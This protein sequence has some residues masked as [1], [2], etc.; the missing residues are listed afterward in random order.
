MALAAHPPLGDHLGRLEP[1]A[2][3]DYPSGLFIR[4]TF[5]GTKPDRPP[6]LEGFLQER[7]A[8]SCPV[9]FDNESDAASLLSAVKEVVE[10]D[11]IGEE[12]G[13]GSS[14]SSAPSYSGCGRRDKAAI[15]AVNLPSVQVPGWPEMGCCCYA[16]PHAA[17]AEAPPFA[18][19]PDTYVLPLGV[20][21]SQDCPILASSPP[22]TESNVPVLRLADVLEAEAQAARA[23]YG[24]EEVDLAGQPAAA[25]LAFE[26]PAVG[27]PLDMLVGTEAC[28]TM[29]SA[30]HTLQMCKPCAFLSKGCASGVECKFCHLCPA[31]EKKKRK[32]AKQAIKRQMETFQKSFSDTFGFGFFGRTA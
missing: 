13:G 29:G 14:S 31:D 27:Q 4:N 10:H 9:S 12:Q 2:R 18:R 21:R 7:V 15:D 1:N 22:S 8:F 25:A 16:G 17:A 20:A 6:S 11:G 19:Q 3:Y 23:L 5:L 28:P 32:K 24:A 30:A 26:I